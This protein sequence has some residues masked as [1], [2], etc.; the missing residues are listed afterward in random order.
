[1]L[2]KWSRA[3]VW[4]DEGNSSSSS[5]SSQ[6]EEVCRLFSCW[7]SYDGGRNV[8]SVLK[9]GDGSFRV[10]LNPFFSV[11]RCKFFSLTETPEDYTIIVDEEGFKGGPPSSRGLNFTVAAA[12]AAPSAGGRGLAPPAASVFEHTLR[13]RV[14]GFVSLRRRV[15]ADPP[16]LP[17]RLM[18]DPRKPLKVCLLRRQKDD[19]LHV[20]IDT[21]DRRFRPHL[22]GEAFLAAEGRSVCSLWKLTWIQRNGRS[23]VFIW[24]NRKTFRQLKHCRRKFF[25]FFYI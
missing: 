16:R 17:G 1:M 24:N 5:S 10:E 13:F 2:M 19:Y 12:T 20:Y 23:T 15:L 18:T 11:R 8:F 21:P 4:E 7:A 22:S 3:P 14:N 6:P 9:K 25:F